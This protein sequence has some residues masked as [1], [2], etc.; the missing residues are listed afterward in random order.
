MLFEKWHM[1]ATLLKANAFT[2]YVSKIL[3]TDVEKLYNITVLCGTTTFVAY[4]ES[5]FCVL[6]VQ[7]VLREISESIRKVPC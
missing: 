7:E 6:K 5:C 4:F 2:R 1:H 3:T